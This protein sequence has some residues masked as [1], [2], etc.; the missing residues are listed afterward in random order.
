M[1]VTSTH[2]R[3]ASKSS[4]RAKGDSNRTQTVLMVSL[5]TILALAPLPLGSNRPVFWA[6]GALLMGIVGVVYFGALALRGQRMRV[7]ATWLPAAL[8]AAGLYLGWI[9][10]QALPLGLLFGSFETVLPT[11]YVVETNTLSLTPGDTTLA[12]LR[13]AGYGMLFFL[14]LQLAGNRDRA[15]HIA[16]ILFF[17]VAGWGLYGL[18]AL[19]Q[20]GDSILV[21]EK[22]AYLGSATGPFVNRNSFA[23]FL[24]MGLVTGLGLA[25]D[26]ATRQGG[27]T[28]NSIT[29]RLTDSSNMHV[30]LLIVISFVVLATLFQTNSRMGVFAGLIG[31]GLTLTLILARRL[32]LG[33]GTLLLV[34]VVLVAVGGVAAW[35]YGGVLLD[36]LGGVE[37]DANV[38]LA[39]YRQILGMISQRPMTG[40]GADS[41]EVVYRAF[42][43][44]PVSLEFSWARAHSTYLAHWAETG[45][46]FGSIPLLLVGAAFVACL[47][48]ALRRDSD[49]VLPAIGAGVIATGAIHSLVDFSLEMQANVWLFLALIAL[50]LGGHRTGAQAARNTTRAAPTPTPR[51]KKRRRKS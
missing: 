28:S 44:P 21:F 42:R 51:R 40:W 16:Q 30:Y 22:W 34:P 43:A 13:V 32:G 19:V 12:G 9:A 29:T 20:F 37:Q 14:M 33:R 26:R 35:L 8:T 45:V 49:I 50:A 18:L 15:K 4:K 47:F 2:I 11:G 23:T 27:K 41:F 38:R 25:A 10:V 46:L 6:L 31:T 24:A 5:L 1:S 17:I 48:A 39:A 3:T 7:T 36:R